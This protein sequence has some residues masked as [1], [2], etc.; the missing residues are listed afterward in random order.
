MLGGAVRWVL[1]AALAGVIVV[2]GVGCGGDDEEEGSTG[3]RTS[4]TTAVTTTTTADPRVEVEEAYLAY[5]DAYLEA[6]NE[7]VTPDLPGLQ[8][9][10]TG[11]HKRTV[12]RNLRDLQGNAWAVREREDSR[13]RN[14][15]ES[16]E[17]ADGATARLTACSY[18]D[19]ITYDVVTGEPVDDSAATKWL[20]G[21]MVREGDRWKVAQLQIVRRENGDDQCPV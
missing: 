7:P 10:M 13:Y 17:L 9:L 1:I 5:W 19:L 20:E 15:L 18:D 12:T 8:V 6:S 16:L 4:S 3:P 2:G 21:Q 11:D 14:V